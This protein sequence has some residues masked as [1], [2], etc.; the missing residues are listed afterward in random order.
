MSQ[1]IE[2]ASRSI[3]YAAAAANAVVNALVTSSATAASPVTYT[4][5]TLNGSQGSNVIAIP[6]NVL[7]T[8]AVGVGAYVAGSTITVT[9]LDGNGSPLTEVLT[10]VGTGGGTT[11]LGQKFFSQVTSIAVQAQAT[12]GGSFQFGVQDSLV[13]CR[14]MRVGTAGNLHVGYATPSG[15]VNDTIP[16]V[17]AGEAIPA[18]VYVLYGD[19]TTTAQ[20]ITVY[21]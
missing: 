1:L 17:Q 12:T 4:G 15:I 5:G 21:K 10:I 19:A 11:I 16:S 14:Q 8:L 9:G 6:R 3:S 7:A 20:N 18:L 2:P 13:N